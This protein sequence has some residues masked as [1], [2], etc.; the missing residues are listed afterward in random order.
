MG[1]TIGT[2]SKNFFLIIAIAGR[3][4]DEDLVIIESSRSWI[5]RR[6]K[7]RELSQTEVNMVSGGD[8]PVYLDATGLNAHLVFAPVTDPTVTALLGLIQITPN[9]DNS[10]LRLHLGGP[11]TP[12]PITFA[13]QDIPH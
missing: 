2:A 8:G 11:V 4:K 13:G 6:Y 12:A 3:N 7:M 10:E 9:P 1:Q 5:E